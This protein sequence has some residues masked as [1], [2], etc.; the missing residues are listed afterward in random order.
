[1]MQAA[2]HVSTDAYISIG[3]IAWNE[4][5]AIRPML[6]S[7]FRQTLFA[8]LAQRSLGCE[9][10]CVAN[11]CTDRTTQVCAEVF[12]AQ[13]R[14]HLAAQFLSCRVTDLP[15]RGKLNAWNQFVH[16]LSCREA[17][18]LF[19]LDADILLH[20]IDTLRR[21]LAA[22]ERES[23]AAVAVDVPRKDIFFKARRSWWEK[24]SLS[25]ADVTNSAEAQ[26]CAQL[27][28]IRAEVARNIYLPKDLFA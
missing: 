15:E 16:S 25:A 14:A 4:E 21:M 17:K 11:G 3:V 26:L 7:L 18:F 13:S 6:E 8:D 2:S 24:L 22:L 28:C 23:Q 9:I 27:Y 1:M 19:L 20:E 12:E 10:I 5:E